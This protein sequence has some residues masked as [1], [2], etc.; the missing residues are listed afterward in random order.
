MPEQLIDLTKK[1]EYYVK[2]DTVSSMGIAPY[3]EVE[4]EEYMNNE[5]E[6]KLHF[7]F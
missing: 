3:Q 4:G 5:R 2:N 7:F 1:S 6:S